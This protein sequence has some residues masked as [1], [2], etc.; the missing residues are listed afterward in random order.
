[1]YAI[2]RAG[3]RDWHRDRLFFLG[4]TVT[5]VDPEA[6]RHRVAALAVDRGTAAAVIA[7]APLEGGLSS[8]TYLATADDGSRFV[9]KMAP[10]GLAPVRNRDVLRQAR[11][12]EAITRAGAA[13]VA[14]VLFT[15]AGAPPD[16]PPLY[17]MEFRAG[18]SFE[19]L[20]DECDELPAPPVI[21]ARMLAAA[22]VLGGLHTVDPAAVGLTD[23][24][25]VALVD[26]VTRWVAIFETV[27]DDLRAGY[28]EAADALLAHLP[29][30]VPATVV[31][32]EYRLGNLLVTDDDV[33]AIIDWELWTREDP[34]VDL[35]WF[36]SYLDADDQPSA[37]RATPRGMPTRAEV[38]AA[39]EQ[40]VGAPV[41]DLAWFDAHARFKMASICAHISKTNRKRE[42]PD[43]AQEARIPVI[44]RLN[45]QVLSLIA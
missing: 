21:R 16:V 32:G 44:A 41:R 17:A 8:L 14:R 30:A 25:E 18:A 7:L 6:L 35:A 15:D 2:D 23:E 45:A 12:Q 11:V 20:L 26:E 27:G 37:I 13:P 43:A 31:H 36:L 40:A 42:H 9:V 39:Y 29:A 19:P 24:P 38:L 33:A 34:R 3:A 10:P 22:R 1:M 28:R 5:S 4:G